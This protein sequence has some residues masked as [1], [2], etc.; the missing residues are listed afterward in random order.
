MGVTPPHEV[1]E[2]GPIVRPS[3]SN[4]FLTVTV[5][6][7]TKPQTARP[8]CAFTRPSTSII[9]AATGGSPVDGLH[10]G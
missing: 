7:A 2:D 1:G 10:G 3:G 9:R 8:S 5:D 4:A 6:I